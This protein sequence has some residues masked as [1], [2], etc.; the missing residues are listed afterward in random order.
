MRMITIAHRIQLM[1]NNKQKTYFR[2]A[3][4]C[5][6]LAYNWGLAEWKRRYKEGERGLSGRKLRNNFNKI[7][8]E[9]FP[10]T[11]EVTKYATAHAFDDLQRAFDNFFAHRAEYPRPH[12]K[13]DDIGSFYVGNDH[14]ER[15]LTDTN[16]SLKFLKGIAYNTKGK[17]QYLNVPNLGRVKMSQ[18]LRFNGKVLGVKVSQDG[19]KFFAS[20][21][22]PITE[23]E[24]LRTHPKAAAKKHGAV[25]IDFGLDEAMTLSDGI[26]IHNPRTLHKHQ[27]KITR[28][29]RQLS[30]RQ[31]AKTKQE[32]LQ[33][34]KRSNNYKKLSHR[35]GREQRHVTAIRQD[36]TQKLTTILTTHY[37][38]ICIEDLNV[39][40]MQR[41]KLAKSVSD[42]AFGEL[43]R[44]IEYKAAMNGVSV[45]VADRFYP[46]SKTC[47][48]CGAKKEDL[49]LKDR[50]FVC[51]ECGH[52]INRDLNAALNL[53]SL[54][55]NQV[56]ADYPELTP[57]DLTALHSRFTL[58]GIATSK[59]ETGRQ[60]KL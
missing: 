56:G 46:S 30:K 18:R 21:Q 20:F 48:H 38:A 34:V 49:T 44:Q 43:R 45:T 23:E 27:R 3:I 16:D 12:R 9:Q 42:M 37:K 5:C 19:D 57:A 47:S 33:G 11:Y 35:L 39:K 55:T 10:F 32:R 24:Y 31:H 4:G 22:V 51:P 14:P 1:P 41:G 29:S 52:T 58:N 2:K 8:G 13:K 26:A 50:T 6:R 53:L 59:V 25:G 7:R 54:I 36:F 17:H 40:G 15:L 28:L 60:R